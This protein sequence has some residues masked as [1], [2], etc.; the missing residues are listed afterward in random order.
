MGKWENF[1]FGRPMNAR[2][3]AWVFILLAPGACLAAEY[4]FSIPLKEGRLP[5]AD[6]Q[7]VLEMGLHLPPKKV[8]RV[9]AEV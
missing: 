8:L 9:A 6:L 5:V 3:M 7:D 4:R 2:L 1:A